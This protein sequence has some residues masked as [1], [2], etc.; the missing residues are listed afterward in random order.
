MK[1]D[2]T[3]H[4]IIG[5]AMATFLAFF[6]YI[7]FSSLPIEDSWMRRFCLVIFFLIILLCFLSTLI[8]FLDLNK[9]RIIK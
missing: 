5:M 7:L 3:F 4:K 6:I 2:E 1:S 9:N 8:F